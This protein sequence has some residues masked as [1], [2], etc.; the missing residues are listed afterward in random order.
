M[1]VMNTMGLPNDLISQF[2]KITNDNTSTKKETTVY[3]TAK[4]VG[5]KLYVKLDGSNPDVLTPVY[6][7]VDVKDGERVAVL[8]KNH[9]AS[10]TGNTSSPAARNETVKE[11]DQKVTNVENLLGDKLSI[12]D[13][14]ADLARIQKL[15][16]ETANITVSLTAAQADIKTLSTDKLDA[17]TANIKYATI[18]KLNATNATLNNLIA[19]HGEFEELTTLNFEAVNGK[20]SSLQSDVADIDTLIFGS[21]SGTTIQT[22]FA[23]A[24]IAQL[25]NAQIKS[26]MIDNVSANKITSGDIITNDVRVLSEDGKLLISDETIQISDDSRVRVQIGKDASNDYSINIWDAAG[27]LMFSKGGITDSAIKKAIIRNDMVS[28]T[29]N[30]HASKLDIDSL[31]EEIN[32]S[33]KT[34]KSTKVYFDDESQTLD[35]VFKTLTTD[36]TNLQNKVNSQGTQ[37]TAIQGQITNKIWQQDINTATDNMSTKYSTLEQSLNSYKTVVSETY[38]TNARVIAAES[39]ITQLTNKITANVSETTNLGTRMTT[40]EQTSTGLTTRITNAEKDI[41]D[42]AKTATNFMSLN[43]TGLVIGDMTVSKLGRN[44]LIGSDKIKIRTGEIDN[45]IFGA[46]VIE[47]AKNNE[48]AMISMLNGTFKIY[49]STN[50]S[51]AGLGIYGVTSDGK[52]RLAFQPVNENDNLTIGWGGYDAKSN[53]T[54]IYGHNIKLIAGN[55][56]SLEC[57]DWKINIDGNL[58]AKATN[59]SFVELIG[60]SS[61]DNVAIGHGGYTASLGKTNIYGNKIHHIVN[62]TSGSAAYKPYYEAGD[63]VEIEWYGAGFISGSS[64]VVFFTIPLAKPAIGGT[65]PNVTAS[66]LEENGGLRV[67]QDGKYVFG[68]ASGTFIPPSSYNAKVSGEGNIVR[69]EATMPNTTNTVNNE[70]CGIHARIKLTFS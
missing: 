16:T 50:T 44:I 30:I 9:T 67:R 14:E 61:D 18:E 45:A 3:G 13:L 22:S 47:L 49:Y 31:F 69:I 70:V 33:E 10:I 58:F 40:I 46:D 39:S 2:V 66:S 60:L 5:E 1:E 48:S 8:I 37:I 28:D 36:T 52:E 65:L 29:A 42:A 35:V 25:G 63:T 59:N 38:A 54:N 4:Y 24:V 64:K 41:V 34:I 32:G 7:A 26:A 12:K 68:A 23:N 43:N 17:E 56:M 11:V 27:N 6:T 21:A 57:G 20:I 53:G 51:E 19:Q 15:E 62:T 55:D